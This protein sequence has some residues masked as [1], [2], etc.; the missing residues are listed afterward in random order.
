VKLEIDWRGIGVAA[1]SEASGALPQLAPSLHDNQL[2]TSTRQPQSSPFHRPVFKRVPMKMKMT[3][4]SRI[5]PNIGVA[6]LITQHH[7]DLPASIHHYKTLPASDDV[8]RSFVSTFLSPLPA[9]ISPSNAPRLGIPPG[10]FMLGIGGGRGAVPP[11][12]GGGGGGGGAEPVGRGGGGGMPAGED[13]A[14]LSARGLLLSIDD[15]GRGGAMVPKRMDASCLAPPWEGPSSSSDDESSEST[16]D[17]S[18]SSC[19]PSLR[20]EGAA[21]SLKVGMAVL[22]AFSWVSR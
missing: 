12:G 13:T 20:A 2:P 9:A 3:V 16:T 21:G 5:Q 7:S 10:A 11:G 15:S 1:R 14:G 22:L 4:E 6:P 19:L 18:S 8:L 17:Q